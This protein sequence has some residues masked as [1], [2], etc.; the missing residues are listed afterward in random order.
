ML[1][2]HQYLN[3]KPIDL[4]P[5]KKNPFSQTRKTS[6]IEQ[7]NNP[8]ANEFDVSFHEGQQEHHK[9]S[10]T[11]FNKIFKLKDPTILILDVFAEVLGFTVFLILNVTALV[12]LKKSKALLLLPWIIVYLISISAS[13]IN[14]SFLLTIHLVSDGVN[15]WKI[16][17]PLATG[18]IFHLAWILVKGVFEDFKAQMGQ[19]ERSQ[20]GQSSHPTSKD[21]MAKEK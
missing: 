15:N 1:T 17:L 12:G 8:N 11:Y 21:T 14:F 5:S 13:Y 4:C 18:I 19:S 9:E 6:D 20:V 3:E 10:P 7:Q 2:Y 16:F